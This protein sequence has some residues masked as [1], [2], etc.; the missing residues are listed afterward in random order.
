[1]QIK[2]VTSKKPTDTV[3]TLSAGFIRDLEN[4]EKSWKKKIDQKVMENR[5][6]SKKT[7]K[8]RGICHLVKN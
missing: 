1:V 6:N 5:E 8:S 3:L 4:L 2:Y 7:W